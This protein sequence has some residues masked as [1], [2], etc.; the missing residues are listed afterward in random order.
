MRDKACDYPGK[1]GTKNKS[2]QAHG[3]F[4]HVASLSR[5]SL[6]GR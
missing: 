4:H 3:L 1:F 5:C 2:E 6:N